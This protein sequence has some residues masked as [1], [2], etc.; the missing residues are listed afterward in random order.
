MLVIK[1]YPRLSFLKKKNIINF[2]LTIHKQFAVHQKK[3]DLVIR[4][5]ALKLNHVSPWPWT[6]SIK[7]IFKQ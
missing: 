5:Q 6:S 4:S 3:S 7:S 1:L 2:Q